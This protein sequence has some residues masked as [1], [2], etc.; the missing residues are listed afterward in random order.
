M[1]PFNK[2]YAPLIYFWSRHFIFR[3]YDSF[4]VVPHLTNTWQTGI[5]HKY[6]DTAALSNDCINVW[7]FMKGLKSL[8]HTFKTKID[9]QK[10]IWKEFIKIIELSVMKNQLQHEWFHLE[11]YSTCSTFFIG[12]AKTFPPPIQAQKL[13]II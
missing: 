11:I 12:D 8:W 13:I 3:F 4:L 1:W 7:V 6:E 9:V 10:W 2:T 5:K